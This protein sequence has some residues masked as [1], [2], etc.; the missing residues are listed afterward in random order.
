MLMNLYESIKNLFLNHREN[1]NGVC[2][3]NCD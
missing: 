2:A 1:E 3:K